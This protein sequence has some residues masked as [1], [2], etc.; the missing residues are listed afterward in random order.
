[1]LL[2]VPDPIYRQLQWLKEPMQGSDNL[3]IVAHITPVITG[4]A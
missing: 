1:M 3:G 2:A 4:G